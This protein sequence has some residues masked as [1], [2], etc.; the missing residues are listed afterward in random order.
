MGI[1]GLEPPILLV[2]LAGI[3]VVVSLLLYLTW[4]CVMREKTFEEVIAEQ[5]RKEQI[6]LMKAGKAVKKEKFKKKFAERR[7][8]KKENEADDAE[9]QIVDKKNKKNKKKGSVVTTSEEDSAI[10]LEI[11]VLNANI[12]KKKKAEEAKAKKAEAKAQKLEAKRLK[13]LEAAAIVEDEIVA[14]G[15]EELS[16][17]QNEVD[18]AKQY[19]EDLETE[20]IADIE[21]EIIV[22]EQP[23]DIEEIEEIEEIPENTFFKELKTSVED[24]EFDDSQVQAL[25]DTLLQKHTDARPLDWSQQGNDGISIEKLQQQI[26]DHVQQVIN[27]KQLAAE[28]ALAHEKQLSDVHIKYAMLEKESQESLNNQQIEVNTLHAR[29]TKLHEDNKNEIANMRIQME[30][31]K[32]HLIDDHSKAMQDIIEENKKYKEMQSK[33][34]PQNQVASLQTQLKITAEELQKRVSI[35]TT[36]DGW[37]KNYE[38]KIGQYEEQLRSMEQSKIELQN[39]FQ[40]KINSLVE[41]LNHE[42]E[43][44]NNSVNEI[45][46]NQTLVNEIGNLKVHID[47]MEQ[48]QIQME[49][50]LQP[51]DSLVQRDEALNKLGSVD[52]I[53][54]EFESQLQD[55]SSKYE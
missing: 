5:R 17:V 52:E 24:A 1:E 47:T 38:K 9:V 8:K 2:I 46:K 23:E 42:K 25:V 29:L 45:E 37:K 14:V 11:P 21:S 30:N 51:D 26:E 4:T 12:E 50:Q 40:Q 19:A 22:E 33:M 27:D 13:S 7:S 41:E 15:V 10:E 31:K 35:E 6:A 53:K 16:A 49:N 32:Q 34:V 20:E 36:Q 39:N 18:M 28:A 44:N 54:V 55:L 48:K 43:M 3:V